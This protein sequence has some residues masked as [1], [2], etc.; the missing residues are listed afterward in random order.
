MKEKFNL[1]STVLLLIVRN[2][3]GFDNETKISL[4]KYFLL[5]N[6]LYSLRVPAII[7]Y[8]KSTKIKG[9]N[10]EKAYTELLFLA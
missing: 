10:A 5:H 9:L 7:S 8:T 3:K 6:E 4:N 1:I 2:K